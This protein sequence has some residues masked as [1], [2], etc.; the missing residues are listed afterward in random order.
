MN[1]NC[2]DLVRIEGGQDQVDLIGL[3]EEKVAHE[4]DHWF[5]R[6]RYYTH[7][8]SDERWINQIFIKKVDS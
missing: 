4:K 8:I 2:G 3:V 5:F 6:V 7:G 1:I